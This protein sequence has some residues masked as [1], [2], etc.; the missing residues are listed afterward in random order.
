MAEYKEDRPRAKADHR[1]LR[2][3]LPRHQKDMPEVDAV[4][5]TNE[6]DRIVCGM[7]RN[8]TNPFALTPPRILYYDL[9]PRPR[10]PAS[11]RIYED[12]QGCDHPCTFCVIPQYRGNF[13]SRRFESVIS[14]SHAT[15]CPGGSRDQSDRPGYDVLRRGFRAERGRVS[16]VTGAARANRDPAAEVGSFPFT[17]TPTRSRRNCSTQS[18]EHADLN[19]I[20]RHAP[21][22]CKCCRTETLTAGS[23]QG[24]FPETDRTYSEDHSGSRARRTSFIAGFPGGPTRISRR[25]CQFVEAA[26]IWT[27]LGVFSYSDEDIE[28]ELCLDGMSVAHHRESANGAHS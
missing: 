10:H 22:A 19:Q 21:S 14:G 8:M 25:S 28:Q 13:R 11:F 23:L 1:R 24:H 6:I 3:A 12:R 20:H 16:P 15:V 4:I 7:R 17:L 5:G 18:P 26:Q 9:T 2:R 27:R